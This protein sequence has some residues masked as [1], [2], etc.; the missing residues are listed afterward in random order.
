[1]QAIIGVLIAITIGLLETG[2]V[3]HWIALGAR[4]VQTAVAASQLVIFN[5]AA[6][7]YVADNS[8]TLM[9]QATT[10]APV[11]V[12]AAQLIS[13]G[14][15]PNGFAAQNPFGQTLQL[16]VLKSATG[17]LQPLVISTGPAIANQEQLVQV[18]AQAGAQ[19]GFI[20][21]ANQA[22]SGM[23]SSNAYGT[24]GTWQVSMTGYTNPG[25]GHLA[26]LLA[27]NGAINSNNYLYRNLVANE[28]QLN[29][30]NTSIGMNNNNI[31]GA[32]QLSTQSLQA[33]ANGSMAAPSVTLANGK[34]VSFN[35]VP[36]GGVLGL[37][38]ANGQSVYLES[39]NG[40]FRLVNS[41]WNLQLFSVDQSGNVVAN[42]NISTGATVQGGYVN[43]TGNVN[44]Q[45]YV[46]VQ[47]GASPGGGCGGSAIGNGPSGTLLCESGVWTSAA[48]PNRTV[49]LYYGVVQN[50]NAG[51]VT[52]DAQ[53]L[54]CATVFIGYADLASQ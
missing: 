16:Q 22:G 27:F 52:I 23:T 3:T 26:S 15:L 11:S 43:S 36:E 30:M 13:A 41:P 40:M 51:V 50:C 24:Y 7:E 49:P 10:T 45:G 44:A 48:T 35:Q 31:T 34:V 20:P 1:M 4:N 33:L 54:N 46:T 53:Y 19:G 37:V 25:A 28:P 47:G 21:Y 5:N 18:A 38:G 32:N 8:S 14:D 39:D 12:T 6:A 9:S 2:S 29:D 42:G 17:T